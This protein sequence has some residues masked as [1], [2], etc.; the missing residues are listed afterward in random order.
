MSPWV[1]LLKKPYRVA[2]TTV[3]QLV[4][5]GKWEELTTEVIRLLVERTGSLGNVQDWILII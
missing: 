3:S 5:T 1:S 2:N 4:F